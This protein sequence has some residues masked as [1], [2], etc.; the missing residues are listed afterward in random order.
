SRTADAAAVASAPD[1]TSTVTGAVRATATPEAEGVS[2]PIGSA[3]ICV[4]TSTRAC[5]GPEFC[6]ETSIS[7]RAASVDT[8]GVV[9]T[10]PQWATATGE[11]LT[12]W[13]SRHRPPPGYQRAERGGL[14]SRIASRFRPPGTTCGV[15]SS[16][17][18]LYPYGQP[19]TGAP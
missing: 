5:V 10:V 19:P 13:T 1:P 4:V 18:E 11:A 16:R 2:C 7:T 15:T 14:S 3:T 6:T 8:S 17:P 9:I 12:R